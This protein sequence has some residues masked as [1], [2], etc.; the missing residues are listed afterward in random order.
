MRDVYR[1]VGVHQKR[2]EIIRLSL[3]RGEKFVESL[4]PGDV[5]GLQTDFFAVFVTV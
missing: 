4:H 2:H 5:A 1:V 3:V